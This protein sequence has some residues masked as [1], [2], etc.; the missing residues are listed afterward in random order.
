MCNHIN[1]AC[2][3][4]GIHQAYF[5]R[6]YL[7]ILCYMWV[8]MLPETVT[9]FYED[10]FTLM[11]IY[12]L[13]EMIACFSS[14]STIH[15]PKLKKKNDL[16]MSCSNEPSLEHKEY[17]WCVLSI[18]SEMYNMNKD[19]GNLVAV[20]NF[21]FSKIIL[22]CNQILASTFAKRQITLKFNAVD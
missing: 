18:W 2:P 13:F 17:S 7:A 12:V 19:R 9:K 20:K 8:K 4:L 22:A 6:M 16:E 15:V 5:P 10:T 21:K 1:L 11:R 14:T 3:V